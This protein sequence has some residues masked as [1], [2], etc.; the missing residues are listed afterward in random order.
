M[1]A[2]SCNWA[3]LPVSSTSEIRFLSWRRLHLGVTNVFT[4]IFNTLLPVPA[5]LQEVLLWRNLR[6]LRPLLCAPTSGMTLPQQGF[7][8]CVCVCLCVQWKAVIERQDSWVAPGSVLRTSSESLDP[9]PGLLLPPAH[10]NMLHTE[11][12]LLRSAELQWSSACRC[13]EE[14][15]CLSVE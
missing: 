10:P 8:G 1:G 3:F 7:S 9:L 5:L 15:V 4:H 12:A 13:R 6:A 14:W 11:A 2:L